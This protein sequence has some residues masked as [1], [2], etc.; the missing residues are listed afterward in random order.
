MRRRRGRGAAGRALA[1]LAS[2]L[3]ASFIMEKAQARI[4]RLGGEETLARE[5]G[6]QGD[7]EPATVRTAEKAARAVGRAIP[8]ARKGAAGEAVHYATGAAFGALFGLLAPRIPAPLVVAGLA[9]G[10]AVWLLNDEA[11]VPALGLSRGPT[12]YPAST[13][14]KALASHLVYG[15]ATEV[16]F[17]L[18]GGAR[19]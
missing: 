11:L 2:G 3:V 13:H 16:G 19:A 18:L 7:L 6:A 5:R 10:A 8:D 9:Y 1:G 15:A 17:R 12:A 4:M 14:A